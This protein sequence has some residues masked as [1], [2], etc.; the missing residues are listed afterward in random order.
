M[1]AEAPS[2]WGP[3]IIWPG[4]DARLQRLARA[5]PRPCVFTNGVFDLLHA[6]HA[7]GLAA[8]RSLGAALVVGVNSDHSAR[9]LCKG[10]GR[11]FNNEHDRAALVASMAAVSAVV[12]FD[13]DAPLALLHALQPEVF[14]KGDDRPIGDLPEAACVAQWNG[15][16]QLIKRTRGLSSSLLVQRIRASAAA[17]GDSFGRRVASPPSQPSP[18][19]PASP[20]SMV[21]P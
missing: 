14:V 1:N 4:E 12:V 8:A 20:P 17:D 19:S 5:L 7:D 16:V 3:L 9:V 2:A 18:A 11:P 13:E 6:G 21:S 15:R 10:A